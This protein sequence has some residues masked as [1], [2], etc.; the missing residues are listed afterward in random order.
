[1]RI[2]PRA[3]RPRALGMRP[4]NLRSAA[5]RPRGMPVSHGPS[6][7]ETA[8]PARGAAR[9]RLWVRLPPPAR[10]GPAEVGTDLGWWAE[11]VALS[12]AGL[13]LTLNVRLRLGT[14]LFVHPAGAGTS[15]LR[16]RVAFT[17]PKSGRWVTGCHFAQAL[18]AAELRALAES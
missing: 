10:R 6:I 17:R 11:V 9:G 15:P 5:P 16:A 7:P 18:T 2:V 4:G 1:M 14:S 13:A 3:G 8:T 12:P